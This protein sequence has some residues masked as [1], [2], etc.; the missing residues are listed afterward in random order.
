MPINE[1]PNN[2]SHLVDVDLPA[3]LEQ[4]DVARQNAIPMGDFAIDGL[5]VATIARQLGLTGDFPGCYL[6]LE[7]ERPIYAGISRGVL[8]R[9]R[10]HARGTTHF[11]ASLAY[12]IAADRMPHNHTRSRAMQTEEFKAQFEAAKTYIRTL[13]VAYVRIDNPLVLYVFEPYCAMHYDTAE[14]NTFETH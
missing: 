3:L 7:R 10:Q 6:L 9:L 4:M 13:N 1:Y 14:W 5:G 12:R 8:Q 11:D 2:F